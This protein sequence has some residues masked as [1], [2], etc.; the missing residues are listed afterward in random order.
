MLPLGWSRA[1]AFVPLTLTIPAVGY[2]QSG[3]L[4]KKLYCANDPV[5]GERE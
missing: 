5:T 3:G 1:K 2:C 4:V